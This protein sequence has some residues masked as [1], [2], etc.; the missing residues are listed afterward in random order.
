YAA[1]L[2]G[3]E[4]LEGSGMSGNIPPAVATSNALYNAEVNVLTSIMATPVASNLV[5]PGDF[6]N[7]T[8]VRQL[9]ASPDGGQVVALGS[10]QLRDVG[11][12]SRLYAWDT[13]TGQTLWQLGAETIVPPDAALA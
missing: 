3:S 7:F 11:A 12:M 13:A 8:G 6:S 10:A 1:T 4:F 9:A 2:E 5:L